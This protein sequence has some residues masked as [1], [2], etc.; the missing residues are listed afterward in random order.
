MAHLWCYHSKSFIW[1]CT[2]N[3]ARMICYSWCRCTIWQ[4]LNSVMD[5]LFHIFCGMSCGRCVQLCSR[6]AQ[7]A[8]WVPTLTYPKGICLPKPSTEVYETVSPHLRGVCCDLSGMIW[9]LVLL[10]LIAGTVGM[11]RE[12][13]A[14]HTWPLLC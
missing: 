7:R 2:I 4:P 1:I 13:A 6:E 11:L 14:A 8:H 12:T 10:K 3:F 5:E 9:C